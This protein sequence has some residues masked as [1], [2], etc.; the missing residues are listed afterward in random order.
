VGA[1]VFS[2]RGRFVLA[3]SLTGPGHDVAAVAALDHVE[4]RSLVLV[5]SVRC[6]AHGELVG[7]AEVHIGDV[8]GVGGPFLHPASAMSPVLAKDSSAVDRV[9]YAPAGSCCRARSLRVLYLLGAY[10][11]SGPPGRVRFARYLRSSHAAGFPVH[12]SPTHF[13]A[14]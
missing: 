13:S 7:L 9:H 2:G 5:H 3:V 12:W 14:P 11:H 10:E 4:F 8:H 1:V 6:W